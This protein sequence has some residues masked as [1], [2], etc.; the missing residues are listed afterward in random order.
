MDARFAFTA[1]YWGD[2]AV[3]CRA[4]EDRPGPL[5]EQQFGE[6][7]TWTQAQNFASKLN[8]GLDL[9]PEEARQIVT[10]SLLAAACVIQEALSSSHLW[11]CSEIEREVMR[12]NCDL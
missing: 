8:E 5:V 7:P 2:G 10:N 9:A 11:P 3:I 6:F 12:L 4:I 1:Q